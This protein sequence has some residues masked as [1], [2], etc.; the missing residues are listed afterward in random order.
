M[1]HNIDAMQRGLINKTVR[2]AYEVFKQSE[3]YDTIMYKY[4][5]EKQK[6]LVIM[7][8]YDKVQELLLENQIKKWQKLSK[9]ELLA[10]LV[11]VARTVKYFETELYEMNDKALSNESITDNC[12]NAYAGMLS[13]QSLDVF[14]AIENLASEGSL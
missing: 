11:D 13:N 9:D 1:K 6:R 5:G 7:S 14:E 2:A 3:E 8:V 4:S 12:F 10:E